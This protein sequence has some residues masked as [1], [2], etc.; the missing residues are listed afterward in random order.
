MSDPENFLL[1]WSRR[2]RA[3]L[4]ETDI[5]RGV[6]S[7]SP[8][9]RG[10]GQG[11]GASPQ[12]ETRS[13]DSWR[14]P[15]TRNLREERANSDLSPEAG[16]GEGRGHPPPT[17]TY[18]AFDPASLPPI[19][20]ITAETDIR[21][22]LRAGVPPEL[23][24]AALRRAFAC[25]PAIRNFVGLAD[26]AWDFN[27]ADSIAGFGPLRTTDDAA[28]M[29]AQLELNRAEPR[30]CNP[31]DPGP[32]IPKA[33]E[34]TDKAIIATAHD[35]AAEMHNEAKDKDQPAQEIGTLAY[36]DVTRR[37]QERVAVQYTSTKPDN[38]NV[39]VKRQH[40]GALPK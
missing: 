38:R 19:Q 13:P 22:F 33:E 14:G 17:P 5:S 27:A 15:L 31:D 32:T 23:A 7:P 24:R 6:S 10:E 8:R 18:P 30:P 3:L 25:D 40:G 11:E 29:A 36:A 21:G 39:L 34:A 28:K 1:R 20:S 37:E 16:R 2:K 9:L 12:A 4:R 35:A 26:Y